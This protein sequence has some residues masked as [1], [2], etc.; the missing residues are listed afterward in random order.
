[1]NLY[2][3]DKVCQL[4]P[5]LTANTGKHMAKKSQVQNPAIYFMTAVF[6][7][8]HW[9]RCP[10]VQVQALVLPLIRHVTLSIYCSTVRPVLRK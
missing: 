4:G 6:S 5:T 10:K 7:R 3:K 1:M 8:E 2:R 9:I